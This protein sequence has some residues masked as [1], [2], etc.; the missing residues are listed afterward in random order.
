MD[1]LFWICGWLDSQLSKY[2][3]FQDRFETSRYFLGRNELVLR[4]SWME[5]NVEDDE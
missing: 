4:H 5:G 2:Q 1:R 3:E